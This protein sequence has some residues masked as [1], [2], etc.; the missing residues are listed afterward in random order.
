MHNFLPML[1]HTVHRHKSCREGFCLTFNPLYA[2][3]ITE[4]L[5]T[6][7]LFHSMNIS[8]K[9]IWGLAWLLLKISNICSSE[10][11]ASSEDS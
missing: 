2:K 7:S 3:L 6:V 9:Y 4:A 8:W 10:I 11:I 5:L 1:E